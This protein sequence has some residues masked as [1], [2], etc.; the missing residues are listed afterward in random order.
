VE[1]RQQGAAAAAA[2][3]H[4][5]SACRAA[6]ALAAPRADTSVPGA[7]AGPQVRFAKFELRNGDVARARQ[8]YER[9][10]QDLG[11]EAQTVGGLTRG[12]A[13]ERGRLSRGRGPA[14]W[15]FGELSVCG[16]GGE[17]RCGLGRCQGL[18]LHIGRRSGLPC[19]AGAGGV[20]PG[21]CRLRGAGQGGRAR[22]RHL[23][24]GGGP[25]AADAQA[26]CC[27]RPATSRQPEGRGT[28]RRAVCRRAAPS[29]AAAPSQQDPASPSQRPAPP[30]APRPSC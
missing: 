28:A 6:A 22:A 18:Q 19:R 24:V 17:G 3:L 14:G 30:P 16:G 29:T 7:A 25:G 11:D 27:C 12:L 21:V 1:L 4:R 2:Q 23:Q 15:G 26:W 10:L 9:G 20:L 13:A 8:C 5:R